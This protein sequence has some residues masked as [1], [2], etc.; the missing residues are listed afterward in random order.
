MPRVIQ[1]CIGFVYFAQWLEQKTRTS[2]SLNQSDAKLAP[3]T[4]GRPRFP[5]L[6][7]VYSF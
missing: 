7:A 1:D 6:Q 5:A 2:P 3:I 4:I